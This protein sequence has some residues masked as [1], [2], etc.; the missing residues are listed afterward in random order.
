MADWYNTRRDTEDI[1]RY[2]AR[3]QDRRP[4]WSACWRVVYQRHISTQEIHYTISDWDAR[5][6]KWATC[7]KEHAHILHKHAHAVWC[8]STGTTQCNCA[9]TNPPPH[10]HCLVHLRSLTGWLKS[11]YQS[12]K[13]PILSTPSPRNLKLPPL[14]CS[15][16]RYMHTHRN[17]LSCKYISTHSHRT[18]LPHQKTLIWSTMESKHTSSRPIILCR[19]IS[20][21]M[22]LKNR[23]VPLVQSGLLKVY[24]VF[25]G[26]LSNGLF[27]E[28]C[29]D[30]SFLVY[31]KR[32]RRG[33][34]VEPLKS[35]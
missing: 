19:I 18:P 30:A 6:L 17:S 16:Q 23:V 2:T 1:N 24:H 10:A 28:S 11:T 31:A 21:I 20:K 29:E 7:C 33:C 22:I 25:A 12:S 9:R 34:F 15:L 3:L 4:C 32:L 26:L 13:R 14:I 5:C 35:D 8:T 27:P